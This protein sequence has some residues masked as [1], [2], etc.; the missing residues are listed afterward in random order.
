MGKLLGREAALVAVVGLFSWL[1]IPAFFDRPPAVT[2][3]LVGLMMGLTYMA[4]YAM[5]VLLGNKIPAG[6]RRWLGPIAWVMAFWGDIVLYEKLL[7]SAAAV[8]LRAS[9]VFLAP[10]LYGLVVTGL[11][12][13]R[14]GV[15]QRKEAALDALYA[16]SVPMLLVILLLRPLV[17]VNEIAMML[18][19]QAGAIY[20]FLRVLVRIYWPESVEGGSGGPLVH[21]PV[22][23]AI[24]GLVEGTTGRGAR[25]YATMRDG[26]KDQEAI[27]VLCRPDEVFGVVEQLVASLKEKPFQVKP[28]QHIDGKVEVVVKRKD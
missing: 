23:D 4:L 10:G 22:P 12:A 11:A 24:V 28:G 17:R 6:I 13:L 20:M 3:G 19:V 26:G 21:R 8:D 2:L 9:Y 7:W 5:V 27:S 1:V 15:G 18:S 25:P 14:A 16:Y